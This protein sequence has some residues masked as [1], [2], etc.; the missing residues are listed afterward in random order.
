MKAV[1]HKEFKT[2]RQEKHMFIVYGIVLIL[3]GILQPLAIWIPLAESSAVH[4][5]GNYFFKNTNLITFSAF[6][7]MISISYSNQSFMGEKIFMTLNTLLA[8]P[9]KISSLIIGKWLASLIFVS[10]MAIFILSIQ[11]LTYFT[12]A[13]ISGV[14]ATFILPSISGV[15]LPFVQI[16]LIWGIACWCGTF[17]WLKFDTYQSANVTSFLITL[18]LLAIE[19]FAVKNNLPFLFTLPL[20]ISLNICIG[21]ITLAINN[22]DRLSQLT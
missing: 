9:V 21:V 2:L 18:P 17:T 4:N 6:F 8:S 16:I 11:L 7:L 19:Y 10:L 13:T 14:P 20:L 15:I 22:R 5:S 3:W 12:L 1:L